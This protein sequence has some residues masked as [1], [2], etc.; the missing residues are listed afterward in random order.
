M[1]TTNEPEIN[2]KLRRL[3]WMGIT[4]DTFTR[5]DD[6]KY[7]WYYDVVDVGYKYHLSDIQ[8]AIGLVQLAKLDRMNKGRE[9]IG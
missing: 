7:S 6:T 8:A 4:K 1:I 3:R 9:E 2:E 5:S